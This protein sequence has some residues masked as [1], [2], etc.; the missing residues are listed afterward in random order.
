MAFRPLLL[1][2]VDMLYFVAAAYNCS[3]NYHKT[4]IKF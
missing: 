3:E 1:S 4:L 2:Y